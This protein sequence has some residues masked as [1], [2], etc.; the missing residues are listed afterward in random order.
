MVEFCPY[1]SLTEALRYSSLVE[2]ARWQE[3]D[4]YLAA[5]LGVLGAIHLSH[6]PRADLLKYVV[7]P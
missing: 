1:R 3:F 4:G 2:R 7:V 6:S 5:K